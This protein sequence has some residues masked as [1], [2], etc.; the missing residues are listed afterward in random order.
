[1]AASAIDIPVT[2]TGRRLS[3]GLL[4]L[5]LLVS[6]TGLVFAGPIADAAAIASQRPTVTTAPT[7]VAMVNIA[8]PNGAGLSYN[9]YQRFDVDPTGLLLNN[10]TVPLTTPLGPIIPAN[11]NLGGRSASLIVNEVVTAVPSQ[12]NGPL[13]VLGDPANVVIANPNGITC[14]GCSF[15][16]T[17]QVQLSTG[18]IGFRDAAGTATSFDAATGITLQVAGGQIRIDGA[19]LSSPLARLDLIA[20]TLSANGPVTVTGSLN[21]LAGRQTVDAESLAILATGAGNSKA[22]IGQDW[23]VDAT[24]FGA[25]NAGSIRIV[26]TPAGMGVRSAA[27]M[28]ASGGDLA[29]NANG[30]LTLANAAASRDIS[31]TASGAATNGGQI[32]AGRNLSLTTASLDNRNRTITAQGGDLTLV[33]T[34]A[35]DNTG[36]TLAGA[37]GATIQADAISNANGNLIAYA[38]DL[39]LT[40]TDAVANSSG[41]IA[42]SGALTLT[43]AS[44]SNTGGNVQAA[45]GNLGVNLAGPLDNTSGTLTAGQSAAIQAGSVSNANGSLIA[46]AGDLTLT[47][48]GA[49]DNSSGL[50]AA[51]NG[52]A[53]TAAS[54]D[55]TAGLLQ[56]GGNLGLTLPGGSFDLSGAQAGTLAAGGALAVHAD[57]LAN[58]GSFGHAGAMTLI[59]DSQLT[60]TGALATG[61]NLVLA[62][63]QFQNDGFLYTGG[64]LAVTADSFTNTGWITIDGTASFSLVH[65]FDNRLAASID[66]S[67]ALSLTAG[68]IVNTGSLATQGSATLAAGTLAN[69]GTL[70]AGT[71]LIAQGTTSLVNTGI[72]ASGGDAT[73]IAANLTNTGTVSSN[74]NLALAAPTFA[75]SGL[76]I[77]TNDLT[78]AATTGFTNSGAVAAGNDA[79]FTLGSAATNAGGLLTAGNDLTL[80]TQASGNLGGIIGANRDLILHLADYTNGAGETALLAGRNLSVSANSLTTAGTLAAYQDLTITTAGGL[81]NS[82]QLLA[83]RD[84]AFTVGGTLANTGAIEAGR[85]LTVTAAAL[86]NGNGGAATVQ[87]YGESTSMADYRTWVLTYIDDPVIQGKLFNEITPDSQVHNSRFYL[88]D[89]WS[90]FMDSGLIGPYFSL[91]IT[92]HSANASLSAGRNLN[93]GVT[94]TLANNASR[95][96]AG[97][98]LTLNAADIQNLASQDTYQGDARAGGGGHTLIAYGNSAADIQAGNNVTLT[99]AT[100]TNTGTIQGNSV[101]LGGALTNGLTNYNPPTPATTLPHAVIDL[102]GAPAGTAPGALPGSA[103]PAFPAPPAGATYTP[104]APTLFSSAAQLSLLAPVGQSY[105]LGLLPPDLRPGATPFLMDAWLEQQTLRQ[106]ALRET[107]QSTFLAGLAY[108]AESGLSVDSQ[109]R[110][111]LYQNAARFAS[112]QGIQLGTALSA[113]QQAQLTQP[114]LWYV[115]EPITAPDGTTHT[116][117]VPRLYLPAGQLDQMANFAGGVIR[118]QD[119]TLDA[120]AGTIDNTGYVIAGNRLTINADEL[121]NQ[122]R[123]AAWGTYTQGVEGGYIE[124]SGDR[125]QPGGFLSAATLDLNAAR[126][127]NISGALLEAGQDKAAALEKALGANFSQSQNI[128]HTVTQLHVDSGFGIEQLLIM[129]VAVVV[130]IYTAGAASE[131]IATAATNSAVAAGTVVAG[132]SAAT[133]V[134]TAAASSAWGMAASSAAGAM[135]SSAVTGVLSGNFSLD[136]VLRSG[137]IAGFTAGLTGM[138]MFERADGTMQSLNQMAN[139]QT[140]AGNVVGTFN[141]DTFGQNLLGMA[142][143]GVMTAGVNTAVYGG[144]FGTAFRDSLVNDLAAVGA[145]AVGLG[146]RAYTPENVAGHALVG[147][148]AAALRGQDAAA[149]AIGGAVGSMV[150]PALIDATTGDDILARYNGPSAAQAAAVTALSMMTSGAVA[151]G[152]GH[153]PAT[154]AQAAQNEALNNALLHAR[155]FDKLRQ[156]CG[157]SSQG[158]CGIIRRVDGTQAVVDGMPAKGPW[159][160]VAHVDAQGRPVA[161]SAYNTL[162]RDVDFVMDPQDLGE[163]MRSNSVVMLAS[164]GIHYL[165]ASAPAYQQRTSSGAVNTVNGL[166]TGNG[167]LRNQGL[168][169]LIGGWVDAGRDPGWVLT[170]ALAVTGGILARAPVGRLVGAEGGASSA[171]RNLTVTEQAIGGEVIN[172]NPV[173]LRWTQRTAGGNGRA[174]ALRDSINSRGY[175]G[176]PIDVV[177]T[178]DGVVTVDHTRAAVALEQGITSIPATVH[179][180]TDSLPASMFGRFGDATTWGEAAA[181]RAANQRP[182]LPPTGTPTPPKLPTPKN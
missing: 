38:G 24:A 1:M 8:A 68:S 61:G 51:A 81:T 129:V 101:Y 50:I 76:V 64:N 54:L 124:V 66:L 15:L 12:L 175:S 67:G 5:W 78:L 3:T 97:N 119:I 168:G 161:Y 75:N 16:N 105:L 111:L 72:L 44:L 176:D 98:D 170:S 156:D 62:S 164:S 179:L 131:M 144:S 109:Q 151:Q 160:I 120:G 13:A 172:I 83:G 94:G 29:I 153:D 33:A 58:T 116:A 53:L 130:T 95:I 110:A 135:A 88:Y 28:A 142:G 104:A 96:T 128:D 41:L 48:T 154:A 125:V 177:S 165:G 174:D 10:S 103:T 112:A 146:T 27:Q 77:A 126:I 143:R 37:H 35:I 84:A 40:A 107:G 26:A 132:S 140:T 82:G 52:L 173:D 45:N 47:A 137:L 159:Q 138:P 108:D 152:L 92:Q 69:S 39:T 46:Y 127:Q 4:V 123:S 43:A 102:S 11:A 93:A 113:A 118:G 87:S 157:S 36:G 133:A 181:F 17:P 178:A 166:M 57:T 80:T 74:G 114:I 22:G 49:V 30:D 158:A 134:G 21:L 60:N 141:A 86:S 117:L 70:A 63:G 34:G 79:T 42:A 55:S 6:P 65:A 148:A 99:A 56:A 32:A 167:A 90:Y 85:D 106:A 73:L 59:A 155:Q 20:E 147:A 91:T 171:A 14:N 89:R 139:V 31:L 2:T 163:F 19:G 23:A 18:S 180:P 169:D 25:M 149:G 115:E 122:A 136:N 121:L 9:R 100:Q 7:G 71:S 150:A 162:S 182:P 145:N